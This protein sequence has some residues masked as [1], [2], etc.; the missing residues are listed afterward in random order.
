MRIDYERELLIQEDVK[1]QVVYHNY[2]T[3]QL[4]S[5]TKVVDLYYDLY[6]GDLLY[7]IIKV[8]GCHIKKMIDNYTPTLYFPIEN[9]NPESLMKY[10]RIRK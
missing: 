4:V 7:G 10:N 5:Y 3:E 8:D 2:Q 6:Y 1:V 9:V